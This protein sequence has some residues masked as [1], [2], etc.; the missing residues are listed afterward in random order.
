MI[1][2]IIPAVIFSTL[3]S[4]GGKNKPKDETADGAKVQTGEDYIVLSKGYGPASAALDIVT[5]DDKLDCQE[6]ES[7][8]NNHGSKSVCIEN[9]YLYKDS[10]IA[11]A[12]ITDGRA[13]V[14]PKTLSI[15]SSD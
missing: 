8:V 10:N 2:F 5:K 14:L 11:L 15:H 9:S 4:C 3:V 13:K 7:S 12:E 1:Q 6:N